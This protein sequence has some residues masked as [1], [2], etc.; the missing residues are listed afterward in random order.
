MIIVIIIIMVVVVVVI[1]V[2]LFHWQQDN[3]D[4]PTRF[5]FRPLPWSLS[6]VSEVWSV[7]IFIFS[8]G[9]QISTVVVMD[10]FRDHG[11]HGSVSRNG[12][13]RRGYGW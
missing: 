9:T 4:A 10:S 6:L 8:Y 13:W 2:D 5:S 7:D 12:W 11:K 1:V 3:E